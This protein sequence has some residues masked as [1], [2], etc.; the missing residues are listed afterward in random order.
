[1]E[2]TDFTDLFERIKLDQRIDYLPDSYRMNTEY[3]S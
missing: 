3:F 1:M 2:K